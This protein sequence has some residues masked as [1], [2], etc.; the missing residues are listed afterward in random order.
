MAERENDSQS[1]YKLSN[2]MKTDQ[3]L[4]KN[5]KI[6]KKYL[7]FANK[8]SNCVK[9]FFKVSKFHIE[10]L[11]FAENHSPAVKKFLAVILVLLISLVVKFAL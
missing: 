9:F 10:M 1:L 11:D 6:A 2:L 8:N 7:E 5:H 4:A 3:Y